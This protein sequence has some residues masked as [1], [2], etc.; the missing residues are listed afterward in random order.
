[1]SHSITI[2]IPDALFE[3]LQKWTEAANCSPAEYVSKTLENFLPDISPELPEPLRM[4]LWSL[5]QKGDDELKS[6][7]TGYLSID[8]Q[9]EMEKLIKKRGI[10]GLSGEDEE[11]LNQLITAGNEM[12][13]K[14]SWARLILKDRGLILPIT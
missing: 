3:R 12:T 11:R 8:C 4:E 9:E 5:R 2:E 6:L 14:K 10:N 1:M 7:A 13:L